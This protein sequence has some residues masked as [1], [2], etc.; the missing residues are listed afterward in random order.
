MS[1]LNCKNVQH[2]IIYKKKNNGEEDEKILFDPK[3]NSP[4]IVWSS[5]W[6][7]HWIKE[8]Y[9]FFILVNGNSDY[10]YKFKKIFKRIGQAKAL[11]LFFMYSREFLL[12]YCSYLNSESE[13]QIHLCRIIGLSDYSYASD[14]ITMKTCSC[15]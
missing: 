5:L 4:K 12:C 7:C 15:V 9:Y 2:V 8:V 1:S 13:K 14:K 6:D 10:K 11:D 3:N